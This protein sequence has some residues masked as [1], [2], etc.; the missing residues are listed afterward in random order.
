[1]NY[2]QF[3]RRL[4]A[5]IEAAGFI[6]TGDSGA[7]TMNK[8]EPG[9]F[10][11]KLAKAL[12]RE[13]NPYAIEIKGEW[14]IPNTE[15]AAGRSKPRKIGMSPALGMGYGSRIEAP[16]GQPPRAWTEQEKLDVAEAMRKIRE[17]ENEN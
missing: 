16:T 13:P 5:Q 3:C 4:D 6:K 1:M 2:K 11:D 8:P 10:A 15:Q 9:S 7:V 12:G 14:S 17:R